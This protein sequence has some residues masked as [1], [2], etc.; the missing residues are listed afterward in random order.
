M[1]GLSSTEFDGLVSFQSPGGALSAGACGLGDQVLPS[2]QGHS[3]PESD[4][5]VIR[6]SP[7]TMQTSGVTSPTHAAERADMDD[8]EDAAECAANAAMGGVASKVTALTAPWKETFLKR[9]NQSL[10]VSD[11]PDKYTGN[12]RIEKESVT[13]D[14]PRSVFIFDHARLSTLGTP[15]DQ[16]PRAGKMLIHLLKRGQRGEMAHVTR[17]GQ[18]KSTVAIFSPAGLARFRADLERTSPAGVESEIRSDEAKATRVKKAR[19][20]TS[21]GKTECPTCNCPVF[22]SDTSTGM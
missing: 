18:Q 19:D 14:A 1:F 22:D 7:S 5:G 21:D 11:S 17:H 13:V 3:A 15:T 6:V 10:T 9:L 20:L 4:F 12:H 16:H 8:V 2:L